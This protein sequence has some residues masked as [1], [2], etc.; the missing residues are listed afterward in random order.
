VNSPA[1]QCPYA[2]TVWLAKF[3]RGWGCSS[4]RLDP[5]PLVSAVP[6]IREWELF[7]EGNV[8][9]VGKHVNILALAAC[10]AEALSSDIQRRKHTLKQ[11]PGAGI[12]E[13]RSGDPAVQAALVAFWSFA[14]EDI[15]TPMLPGTAE[16]LT[17]RLRVNAS[18]SV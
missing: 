9:A 3:W 14:A 4:N 18:Q 12:A 15:F 16:L 1:A 13:E 17:N 6:N 8:S 7:V 10:G 5:A 2:V 11:P